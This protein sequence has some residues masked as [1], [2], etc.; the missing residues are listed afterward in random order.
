MNVKE[1]TYLLGWTRE[2]VGLA[3]VDG[4]KTAKDQ[5]VKLVAAKQDTD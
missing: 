1:V 2:K 5:L 4:V 3:I